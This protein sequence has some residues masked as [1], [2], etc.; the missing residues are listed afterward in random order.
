M[1]RAQ[2]LLQLQEEIEKDL[3]NWQKKGNDW[4]DIPDDLV[5]KGTKGWVYND[6]RDL[7]QTKGK[8]YAD[9]RYPSGYGSG[10][11]E[12]KQSSV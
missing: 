12:T 5:L 4:S 2:R 8:Y 9:G 3:E 10:A 7:D 11:G 6:Q 1:S